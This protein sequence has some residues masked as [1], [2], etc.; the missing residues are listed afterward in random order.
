MFGVG[1]GL[2]EDARFARFV[3]GH[4]SSFAADAD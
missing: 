1:V 4:R 2:V 3:V